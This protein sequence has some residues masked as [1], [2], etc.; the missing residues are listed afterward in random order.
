MMNAPEAE[1]MSTRTRYGFVQQF[2]TYGTEPLLYRRRV[3][4]TIIRL[5]H[6]IYIVCNLMWSQ[7]AHIDQHHE[8]PWPFFD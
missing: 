4:I 2:S 1:D 6:R 7:R 8:C 3:P 5:H